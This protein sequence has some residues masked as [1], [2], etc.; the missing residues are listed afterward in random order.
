MT[1]RGLEYVPGLIAAYRAGYAT[2]HMQLGYWPTGAN[3]AWSEAQQAMTELHI[4]ALEL[5]NAVAVADIGCGL[6]G[7]LREVNDR[8][9]HCT[10]TGVNIDPRQLAICS[11][12]RSKNENRLNWVEASATK[13]TL[14][15]DSQDRVL[16]L[17]AMFHFPSRDAFLKEAYRILKPAGLLVCS[18]ILFSAPKTKLEENC[19]AVVVREYG[20]WPMPIA[21]MNTHQAIAANVGFIG[22]STTDLSAQVLPTWQH[23][24]SSKDD[25]LSN[26]QAAMKALHHKG[27]L[28]Y[29]ISHMRKPD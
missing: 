3:L 7:S 8:H 2:D 23:I 21:K 22:V 11:G 13:T 4:A 16:S 24:V 14:N 10:L 15:D 17:E 12:M 20:P 27:R 5:D 6:G 9:S 18:D 28:H 19:L 1:V 29:V 25:P 26:P